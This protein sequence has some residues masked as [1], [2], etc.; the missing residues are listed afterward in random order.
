MYTS[1]PVT[2]DIY[3]VT[4]TWTHYQKCTNGKFIVQ[5]C[6]LLTAYLTLDQAVGSVLCVFLGG[7]V[8]QGAQGKTRFVNDPYLLLLKAFAF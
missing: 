5:L 4:V 8:D 7:I 2:T 6:T 1:M 3:T